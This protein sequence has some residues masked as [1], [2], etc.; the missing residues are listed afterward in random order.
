MRYYE[1]WE[2]NQGRWSINKIGYVVA[3]PCSCTHSPN[4]SLVCHIGLYALHSTVFC[5]EACDGTEGRWTV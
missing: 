1:L 2:Q 4:C 3:H 5:E